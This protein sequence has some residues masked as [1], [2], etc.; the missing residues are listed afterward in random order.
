MFKNPRVGLIYAITLIDSVVAGGMGPLFNKYTQALPAKQVWVMA[1]SALLL[2]LQLVVS[3]VLGALSDK[4]GRRPVL[5]GTA[6][7]SFFASFLLF[8]VNAWGYLSNRALEGTTNGMSSVLRSAVV[9]TAEDND[10]TQQTSVQGNL[11]ALGA[12]FGPAIGGLLIIALPQARFDPIPLVIMGIILALIN[13]GLTLIFKETNEKEKQPV[14]IQE[15]KKKSL[16]ALKV[17]ALWKQLD[18]VDEKLKGFKSLY[19]LQLLSLLA[20]GYYNYFIAYLIV[21]DLGLTPRQAVYFFMYYGV[22]TFVVNLVFF[23]L[24]TKRI[25]QKKML[26]WVAIAGIGVMALYAFSG[27]SVLMLYI[28]ATVDSVTVGLLAG[29]IAGI[30]SQLAAK[31]E[32]QG[33]IFGD[34]QALGGVASFAAAVATTLLTAVDPR[35]PF[36]FYALALAVLAYRAATLPEEASKETDVANQK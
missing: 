12:I 9:D 35:A 26:I 32:G 28:A 14:D 24:I 36:A 16:S 4:I 10:V 23:Q 1:G 2:G 13:V 8:P 19:I 17:S 21:G 33:S 34:T 25:N 3:P 30:T 7:G 22:I 5:I 20:L 29:L 6:I 11:T 31:G 27:G 15:L 18:V